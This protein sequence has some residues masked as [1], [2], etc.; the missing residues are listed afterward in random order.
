MVRKGHRVGGWSPRR[1]LHLLLTHSGDLGSHCWQEEGCRLEAASSPQRAGLSEI[2]LGG[3]N[4]GGGCGLALQVPRASDWSLD[5]VDSFLPL[6]RDTVSVLLNTLSE[7]LG[8]PQALVTHPVA[9]G[10]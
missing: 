6:S 9:W 10:Q 3:R 2:F 4:G 8:P 7:H 5:C 1:V